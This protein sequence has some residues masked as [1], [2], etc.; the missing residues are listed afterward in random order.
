MPDDGAL[1]L[2]KTSGGIVALPELSCG[3]PRARLAEL[4]VPTGI[5][6]DIP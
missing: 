3:G 6:A 1:V 2:V 4:G 5:A